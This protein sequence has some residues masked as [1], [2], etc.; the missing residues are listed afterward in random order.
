M[1]AWYGCRFMT[2]ICNWFDP[3][4]ASGKSCLRQCLLGRHLQEEG[5]SPCG[6]CEDGGW[7]AD[8]HLVL[9]RFFNICQTY[10]DSEMC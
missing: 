9:N 3:G 8:D 2:G 1:N 6:G 10:D 5:R 4:Q 7:G